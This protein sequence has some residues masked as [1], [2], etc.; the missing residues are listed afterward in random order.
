MFMIQRGDAD[1]LHSN[2]ET[3]PGFSVAIVEAQLKG[4][5]VFAYDSKV[6]LEG[7]TINRRVSVKI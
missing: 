1:V 7:I 5:E 3:D 2:R 4:V 6:T